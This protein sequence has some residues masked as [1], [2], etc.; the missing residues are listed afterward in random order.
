MSTCQEDQMIY[1]YCSTSGFFNILRNQCLWLTEA[2][3]TN[4]AWEN[5]ML[6]PIFEQ[7]LEDLAEGE[8]RRDQLDTA[9]DLYYHHSACFIYLGCFRG[10]GHPAPVA[11]LCG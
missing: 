4:D 8:V 6:D 9:R 2:S 11:V 1:H 7:A 10:R 5:R 3:F